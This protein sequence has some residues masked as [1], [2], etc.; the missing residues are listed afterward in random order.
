MEYAGEERR[1]YPDGHSTPCQ[2][3][4][5]HKALETQLHSDLQELL[6]G[7]EKMIANQETILEIVTAWNN[8]K[9]F[10]KTLVMISTVL[11]WLV[12]VCATVAGIWYAL[13][14]HK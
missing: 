8:T 4:A 7:Q 3:L 11:K 13:V 2:M 12:V 1:H 14:E 9:G 6:V 10:V 5:E